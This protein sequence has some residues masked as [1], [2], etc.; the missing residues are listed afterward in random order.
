[1][2]AAFKRP[3]QREIPEVD[4]TLASPLEGAKRLKGTG[5]FVPSRIPVLCYV[6]LLNG[7]DEAASIC[8]DAKEAKRVLGVKMRARAGKPPPAHLQ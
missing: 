2:V 5:K 7:D 6:S 3:G 4:L 1:M 8:G